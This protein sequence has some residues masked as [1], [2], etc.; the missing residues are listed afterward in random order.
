MNDW[1]DLSESNSRRNCHSWMGPLPGEEGRVTGFYRLRIWHGFGHPSETNRLRNLHP[2]SPSRWERPPQV[3]VTVQKAGAMR[4]DTQQGSLSMPPTPRKEVTEPLNA[5][6]SLSGKKL[7]ATDSWP[8]NSSSR[9]TVP[10]VQCVSLQMLGQDRAVEGG[11]LDHRRRCIIHGIL[12]CSFLAT[13][14]WLKGLIQD[15]AVSRATWAFGVASTASPHVCRGLC[16]AKC[17]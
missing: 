9:V 6:L 12:C 2:L 1:Q 7:R 16:S 8:Q 10:S 17:P 11:A 4:L 3:L 14:R 15:S 5:G 13:L